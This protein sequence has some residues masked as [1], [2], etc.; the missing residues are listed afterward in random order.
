MPGPAYS[1]P[2]GTTWVDTGRGDGT[3]EVVLPEGFAAADIPAELLAD[4][5]AQVKRRKK[6]DIVDSRT[7]KKEKSEVYE[8]LKRFGESL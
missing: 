4:P 8:L 2:T 6:V 1:L 3:F 5:L 7:L